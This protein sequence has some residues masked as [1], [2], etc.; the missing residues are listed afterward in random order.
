MSGQIPKCKGP[1]PVVCPQVL[2]YYTPR[3]LLWKEHRNSCPGV[4][5]PA[6]ETEHSFPCS[7]KV[8]NGW[9]KRTLSLDRSS[10]R[11]DLLSGFQDV[12]YGTGMVHIFVA[13]KVDE[14]KYSNDFEQCCWVL[15]EHAWVYIVM[16]TKCWSLKLKR[17][18][19][20]HIIETDLEA[21]RIRTCTGL[22]WLSTR[23]SAVITRTGPQNV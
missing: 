8:K 2:I 4:K 13:E 14:N 15:Q 23:I 12:L 7:A 3:S 1:P 22:I 9:Q 18:S 20:E 11:T 16:D 10:R 5:R 21:V 17:Q 19:D 6:R